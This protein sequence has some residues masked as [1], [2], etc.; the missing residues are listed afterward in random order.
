M[1]CFG[2]VLELYGRK[3]YEGSKM[4]LPKVSYRIIFFCG[5]G[6]GKEFR[7]GAHV[8]KYVFDHTHFC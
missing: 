2:T 5:E 1:V 6:W 8:G 7:K 4:Y 3:T